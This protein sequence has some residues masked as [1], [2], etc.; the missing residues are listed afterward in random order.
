MPENDEILSTEDNNEEPVVLRSGGDNENNNE[1][2]DDVSTPNPLGKLKRSALLHYIATNFDFTASTPTAATA[3]T[4]YL[5]G[6]DVEDLSVELNSDT[7]TTKNILD[8]VSVQDNGYEPSVDVDTYYATPTDGDI[9]TK[10]KDIM[11][12]R[13][14]GDACRTYILEV[15]VD[16]DGTIH[17]AWVEEVIVKPTSYGG[18]TGGVRIPFNISFA[19]NRQQGTVT[20]SGKVPTFATT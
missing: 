14:T 19:G 5:I 20:F 2:D 16:T 17:D 7:E 12:N 18:A 9:Y 13:K 1:E 11:M 8:E 4:W 6:K 3:A 15:I 10:L